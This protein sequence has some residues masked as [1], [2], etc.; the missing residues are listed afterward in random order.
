[1]VLVFATEL[2]VETAQDVVPVPSIGV[3]IF[4]FNNLSGY[5]PKWWA[6]SPNI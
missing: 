6:G 4:Q 5:N 2:L 3:W 1:M